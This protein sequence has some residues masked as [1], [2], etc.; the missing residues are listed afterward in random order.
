MNTTLEAI[1]HDDCYL[2][3]LAVTRAEDG[4]GWKQME[5]VDRNGTL[6]RFDGHIV[7]VEWDPVPKRLVDS[8]PTFIITMWKQDAERAVYPQFELGSSNQSLASC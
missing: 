5:V 2:A 4:D 6:Y 8:W 3:S 1:T 7:A